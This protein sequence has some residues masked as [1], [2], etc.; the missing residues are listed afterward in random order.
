VAEGGEDRNE[1]GPETQLWIDAQLPPSL[2]RW[3]RTEHGVDAVHLE[4]LDLLGAG[5]PKIFAAARATSRTVV[6]MTKDDD[7]R[8]I[9]LRKGP[10]PQVIWLRCGNV[11]NRE[12]RRI[13]LEAWPDAAALLAAGEALVEVRRRRD[14][15]P[16]SA[17][18]ADAPS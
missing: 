16:E 15:L 10:P 2:A 14:E 1:I 18:R 4:E 8:E 12:L 9:V 3:L 5:D 11:S 13:V 17:N 6:L 7:F